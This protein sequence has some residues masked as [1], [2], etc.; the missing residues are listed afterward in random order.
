MSGDVNYMFM[1]AMQY[2]LNEIVRFHRE[3]RNN[4]KSRYQELEEDSFATSVLANYDDYLSA[5]TFLMAYS[6]FEEYL[7]LIWKQKARTV[8]RGNGHS[9]TRYETILPELGIE[10]NHPSWQFLIKAT[11]IR[12]C[13][14]H[15]NGRLS[16]MVKS[17]EEKI[18]DI[19]KEF[20][21]EL[22]VKTSDRLVVNVS[23]LS[24]FVDEVREF[25]NSISV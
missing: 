9:I 24:R 7:Y 21:Y 15:A 23:F 6:Y 13:L 25:Q 19:V 20:P 5:N 2:N 3:M 11:H 12:H 18:R 14:L 22:S 1:S 8:K 17:S 10:I 16:F 4:L